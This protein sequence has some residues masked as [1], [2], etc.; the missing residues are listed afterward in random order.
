LR[1]IKQAALSLRLAPIQI[2]TLSFFT[3]HEA[4]NYRAMV[5]EDCL[6]GRR[7]ELPEGATMDLAGRIEGEFLA[8]TK[9]PSVSPS[10]PELIP[11]SD[12]AADVDRLI[13]EE[14]PIIGKA[15]GNKLGIGL[16]SLDRII[17]LLKKPVA[18]GG[19]ALQNRRNGAG[20]YYPKTA[21][22]QRGNAQD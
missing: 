2:A 12:R 21:T 20:Y 8:A 15:I 17:R 7:S 1:A 22:S 11:L 3:A 13:R 14:G 10:E 9:A 18:D 4:A 6:Q 16:K 19:R 5:V